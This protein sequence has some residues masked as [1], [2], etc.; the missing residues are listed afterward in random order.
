MT[1]VY[2]KNKG[3]PELETNVLKLNPDRKF[4]LGATGMKFISIIKGDADC[5]FYDLGV[6]FFFNFIENNIIKILVKWYKKMGYL[7][8][9]SLN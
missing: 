5:Y 8:W 3:T 4:K 2:S 6:K 7:R 1:F 9:R